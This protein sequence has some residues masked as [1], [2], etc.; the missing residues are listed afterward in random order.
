MALTPSHAKAMHTG[1]VS[2]VRRIR[3]GEYEIPGS[4]DGRTYRITGTDPLALLCDC[5]AARR[6]RDCYH[7]AAVAIRITVERTLCSAGQ[8][9]T[10]ASRSAPAPARLASQATP[11]PWESVA[12]DATAIPPSAPRHL[13]QSRA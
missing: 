10:G 8:P 6:G 4:P 7:R 11:V 13:H 9:V 5:P 12:P 2:R 1:S 3:H